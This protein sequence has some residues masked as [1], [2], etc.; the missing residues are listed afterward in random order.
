MIDDSPQQLLDTLVYCLGLNP[1]LHSGRE[2]RSL[3]PSMFSFVQLHDRRPSYLQYREWGSK[4]HSGGLNDR[5]VVNKLVKFF[6]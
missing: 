1:A 2:H 6:F 4:I 5:K 3:K